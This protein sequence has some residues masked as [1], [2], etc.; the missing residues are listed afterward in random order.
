MNSCHR[1]TLPLLLLTLTF[2][3]ALDAQ[4]TPKRDTEY[5]VAFEKNFRDTVVDDRSGRMEPAPRLLLELTIVSERGPAHVEIEAPGRT[6]PLQLEIPDGA[7]VHVPIDPLAQVRSSERPQRLGVHVTSDVPIRVYGLNH[8]YQTTDTYRALPLE[9]LGRHYRAIGFERLHDDLI[10]QLAVVATQDSTRVRITPSARTQ[11][12]RAP[13]RTFEVELH[14]GEAYQ[15][16]A[17]FVRQTPSD[18]TGTLIE[19]DRPVAVFSGHNCAYVP[20][21]DTKSCNTL[22][23]ELHPVR[24]WGTTFV[25]PPLHSK[26]RFL[27]RV[28]AGEDA[29]EIRLDGNP[30]TTLDAGDYYELEGRVTAALIESSRPVEV[31]QYSYGFDDARAGSRTAGTVFTF[32]PASDAPVEIDSS[33]FGR[34]P[35]ATPPVAPPDVSTPSGSSSDDGTEGQAA[36]SADTNA[37]VQFDQPFGDGPEWVSSP[38]PDRSNRAARQALPDS[39]VDSARASLIPATGDASGP[40][41]DPMMMLVPPTESFRTEYVIASP[42]TGAWHRFVNLV[43]PR[44]RADD[45]RIDGE[46]PTVVT[47]VRVDTGKWTVLQVEVSAGRHR[48][49]C[50]RP[51]GA[52]SY[53]FGYNSGDD[54]DAYDAYG[55][56]E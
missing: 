19:S 29:T 54:Q 46:P 47:P 8:R 26:A 9:E 1:L 53:G 22:V 52:M 48:I 13:G 34:S 49:T 7:S 4:P 12:D 3:S 51:F 32:P 20:D 15:V 44:D 14:R 23:E 5:W 31:A 18:L 36:L 43:V 42:V 40:C 16:I 45:V 21:R 39:Y 25:V 6:E 24:S 56:G 55:N 50:S 33:T 35:G 27:F 11:A 38:V 41:G 2:A 28:I 30:L 37:S 17:K 10:S